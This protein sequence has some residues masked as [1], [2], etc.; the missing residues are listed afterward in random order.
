MAPKWRPTLRQVFALSLLGLVLALGALL[1]LGFNGSKRTI[2]RSSENYRDL[3]ARFI[4]SRVTAYLNQAPDAVDD[5]ERK[6]QYGLIDF[7]SPA[8]VQQALLSLLLAN[9][10][11]SEATLTYADTVGP[12]KNGTAP[13]DPASVGQIAIVRAPKRGGFLRRFTWYENGKFMAS[14]DVLA[15]D[16]PPKPLHSYAV[17]DPS[18]H[19]TFQTAYHED[20]GQL[21]ITDLH[22]AQLDLNLPEEKRRVE[23]SVQKTVEDKPGHFAGVL[24]VGLLAAKIDEA[25]KQ[26]ITEPGQPD[27]HLIFLCDKDGRL[28]TGFPD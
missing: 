28:I 23:V 20:Y 18:Q 3:A 7:K 22:W 8:S 2:L 12:A 6:G 11:L 19:D 17:P 16:S 5:F 10:N 21:I 15:P 26:H 4:S 13:I 14:N 9:E 1:W 24:R 25:V 27:D